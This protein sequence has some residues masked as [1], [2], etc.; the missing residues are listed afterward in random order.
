MDDIFLISWSGSAETLQIFLDHRKQETHNSSDNKVYNPP[1]LGRMNA[2]IYVSHDRFFSLTKRSLI[3]Y[4]P[5]L[6]AIYDTI[7][8]EDD[9]A[10]SYQSADSSQS[11]AGRPPSFRQMVGCCALNFKTTNY[12]Y[13][14]YYLLF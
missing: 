5:F 4:N 11:K 7:T 3:V 2:M 1:Y 10:L 6:T 13:Y 12:Y 14:S 8:C 9:M